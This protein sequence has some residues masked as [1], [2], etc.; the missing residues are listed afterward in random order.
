VGKPIMGRSKTILIVDDDPRFRIVI[1]EIILAKY[2]ELQIVEAN[3][4]KS[5]LHKAKRHQPALII[6]DIDFD[7]DNRFQL[8]RN[9]KSSNPKATILA[10]SGN[11]ALEY[12]QVILEKGADYFLSKFSCSGKQIVDLVESV[13]F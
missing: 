6:L 7:I 3:T 13:L 2:P 5:C 8:I 12:Q 1:K 10:M 11:D 4:V 9:L